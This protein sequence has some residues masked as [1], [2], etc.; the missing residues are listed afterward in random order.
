MMQQQYH[1]R[2]L[3]TCGTYTNLYITFK[4]GGMSEKERERKK[5]TP[6]F[7]EY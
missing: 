2:V 3:L 6:E 4:I 1:L 7:G 5:V